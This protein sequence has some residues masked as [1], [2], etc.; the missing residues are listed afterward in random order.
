MKIL[1]NYKYCYYFCD[2]MKKTIL[3]LLLMLSCTNLPAKDKYYFYLKTNYI[4]QSDLFSTLSQ[5]GIKSSNNLFLWCC[6]C[7]MFYARKF[8][9]SYGTMNLLIFVIFQPMIILIL[10]LWIIFQRIR[11]V[12][13]K[14]RLV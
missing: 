13:L 4:D 5:K 3:I 6:D 10:F 8:N 7:I 2:V 9:I 1:G 11:I 12:R 14:R